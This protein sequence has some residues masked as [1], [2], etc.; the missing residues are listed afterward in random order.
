[1]GLLD[2]IFGGMESSTKL[3]A[4]ESFAGILLA[5][6]GCDGHVADDEVQNLVTCLV[7]MKL[8]QRFNDKQYGQMLNKLLGTMKKKGVDHLL[9]QCVETLPDT[10]KLPVFTNAVD[11]VLADGV[12]EPDEKEFVEKLTKM[13]HID[14]AK[15]KLIVG[16]MV[17]KNRG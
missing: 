15:A 5:A 11:I 13:L 14:A 3:T 1:M 9:E 2:S 7:R 16:V 4:P 6:S 17:A 8:Y 10:L 12:V